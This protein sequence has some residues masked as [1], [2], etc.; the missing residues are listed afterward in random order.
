MVSR[1]E[2]D[3]TYWFIQNDRRDDDDDS[4]DGYDQSHE[5]RA[6]VVDLQDLVWG[7]IDDKTMVAEGSDSGRLASS[8]RWRT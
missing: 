8:R 6:D 7:H 2:I 1:G 4:D 5:I 3:S